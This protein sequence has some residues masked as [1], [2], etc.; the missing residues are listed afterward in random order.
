MRS[1]LATSLCGV[2]MAGCAW[3]CLWVIAFYFI[4]DPELAILLFPFSLRLGMT[5]HTRTHYWPAIYIAEWGLAIALALLLDE[6]QWLT[7]LIASGLSI[8]ATLIAK[9][10]YSGDQNRHLL[11]MASLIMVTAFINVAVVGSHVPAVYMVWLVSITGGL[12]LVPMCYLVWNYL[13]QN[14]WAPL[15]SYLIHN[16][17][18]FKIRHI[19]LYSV[20]LVASILIQT[21]LPDELRRFAPFCM[22][23]PIILLAVRYGW[24][25]ALLATMLNSVALIA[26]H[27][28]TS[29]LEIT[30]LLLSLSAQTITGILLGL[31]VQKQKDLNSKLRSE[32]S[33]NQ[34]LSR[35]LVTAEES[36]RRDIARELH[37]EIGQ[38]ITA[39]RT[40]AR[41]SACNNVK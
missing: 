1:Y 10:Y 25:G 24:Q 6:P 13:F 8:P 16:V 3:F 20:L 31:A 7:I 29:K 19:A 40:Q 32:L 23:I 39:I 27:S 26:A 4:N 14:K 34:N 18:E 41:R 30:D 2:F 17:V 15:S 28:G 22:A 35:Q 5:L 21:S 11:V 12:M 33:R 38:N 9:R 37:D 36:V